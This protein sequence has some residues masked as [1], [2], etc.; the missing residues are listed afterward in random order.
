MHQVMPILT[1]VIFS[2][3]SLQFYCFSRRPSFTMNWSD[4]K[5]SIQL[6]FSKMCDG[7]VLPCWVCDPSNFVKFCEEKQN[8]ADPRATGHSCFPQWATQYRGH[9]LTPDIWYQWTVW[10]LAIL[11]IWNPFRSRSIDLFPYNEKIALNSEV[12]RL[13]LNWVITTLHIRLY[14]WSYIAKYTWTF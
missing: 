3:L 11:Q 12:M 13:Q 5:I 7:C 6:W 9:S 1:D 4:R 2:H 8:Y 10:S 14:C